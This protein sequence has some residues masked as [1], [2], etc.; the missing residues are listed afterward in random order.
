M[1]RAEHVD[2]L[3]KR[4]ELFPIQP[5]P[6]LGVAIKRG[7]EKGVVAE[8]GVQVFDVSLRGVVEDNVEK[9]DGE[10]V[11]TEE[12]PFHQLASKNSRRADVEIEEPPRLHVGQRLALLE[13]QRLEVRAT[14]SPSDSTVMVMTEK[15]KR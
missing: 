15:K 5:A 9:P 1:V 8:D 11:P 13:D 3:Q 12:P 7:N 4:Y 10:H 2:V 14:V 6:P